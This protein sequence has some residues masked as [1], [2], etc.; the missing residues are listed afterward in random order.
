MTEFV[1]FLSEEEDAG[2]TN[3]LNDRV[4]VRHVKIAMTGQIGWMATRYYQ[5]RGGEMRFNGN[6]GLCTT[7]DTA[8]EAGIQM[9]LKSE[10]EFNAFLAKSEERRKGFEA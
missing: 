7:P 8:I 4:T 9:L 6:S 1:E 5:D 10:D 2:L 3:T